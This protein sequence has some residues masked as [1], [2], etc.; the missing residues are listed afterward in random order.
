MYAEGAAYE[1]EF[2]AL[3]DTRSPSKRCRPRRCGPWHPR[4]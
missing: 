3:T 2:F 1:V 4:T